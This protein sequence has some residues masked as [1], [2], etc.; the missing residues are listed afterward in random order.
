MAPSP[1]G[2]PER[3]APIL[4][5]KPT[6]YVLAPPNPNLPPCCSP[7]TSTP[8]CVHDHVVSKPT[9]THTH[10]HRA[11]SCAHAVF[12]YRPPCSMLCGVVVFATDVCFVFRRCST[13]QW[14]LPFASRQPA[15]AT[16]RVC[17][18]TR[19]CPSL[20][21]LS[22]MRTWN[23]YVVGGRRWCH[24]PCCTHT[25][26][27]FVWGCAGWRATGPQ[28]GQQPVGYRSRYVAT[29]LCCVGLS[30]HYHH[31]GLCT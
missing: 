30:T 14:R 1:T 23:A 22:S 26:G 10:T 9:H 20:P 15:E 5:A 13:H 3:S 27:H 19:R 31:H 6:T 28:A 17:D 12:R 8:P 29:V 7:L 18:S 11:C 24:K 16:L 21:L 4:H 25:S 2:A